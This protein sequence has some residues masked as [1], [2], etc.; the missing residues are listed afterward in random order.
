MT[1]NQRKKNYL[2]HIPEDPY[3]VCYMC[4][5][6]RSNA[7]KSVNHYI[8]PTYGIR[9]DQTTESKFPKWAKMVKNE[10]D[11]IRSQYKIYFETQ[12]LTR[13]HIGNEAFKRL[14]FIKPAKWLFLYYLKHQDMIRTAREKLQNKKI[15]MEKIESWGIQV[16]D[17][18]IDT[19]IRFK[20]EPCFSRQEEF[21]ESCLVRA[22]GLSALTKATIKRKEI[23]VYF[24]TSNAYIQNGVPLRIAGSMGVPII[25]FG[26]NEKY[27]KLTT[28][29][30]K[31][32][33]THIIEYPKRSDRRPNE[34]T[35]T[36]ATR[37]LEMRINGKYDNTIPELSIG[38]EKKNLI[39]KDEIKDSVVIL[40]HDFLDSAHIYRS[41]LFT[42]FWTWANE[43]INYCTNQ[44]YKV[45]VK[46]HP[47][48]LPESTMV[49]KKLKTVFKENTN[50][51]FINPAIPT[52]YI[53]GCEP[54][55]IVS[56][57]GSVATEAAYNGTPILLAGDHPAIHFNLGATART[58]N[59]Y[60]NLLKYPEL[61][62]KGRKQD[63]IEYL[64][65]R[66]KCVFEKSCDSIATHFNINLNAY[67]PLELKSSEVTEYIDKM[68]N[69]IMKKLTEN[70]A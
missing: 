48:E 4:G 6:I 34:L 52:G 8:L 2:L 56:V 28:K 46:P 68:S 5:I 33:A 41:M 70:G 19:Y 12:K 7:R 60:F 36:H 62:S 26:A 53:F 13:D 1:K 65:K 51:L 45:T 29:E 64:A 35:E 47:G 44:G 57:Y 14:R 17:L 49:T 55:L 24:G 15:S 30:N 37:T 3:Y 31:G 11:F 18:I 43:T 9:F 21:T 61:I 54:K 66:Y 42:D 16:G 25:T 38:Q 10:I 59:E 23:D 39:N 58:K 67:N 20:G 22:I 63:A 40:L 69:S 32:L 50:V 27:F